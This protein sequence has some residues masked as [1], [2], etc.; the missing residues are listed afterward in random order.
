MEQ[1]ILGTLVDVPLPGT[2]RVRPAHL[3]SFASGSI[4]SV[5]P[6][7]PELPAH[8]LVLPPA[9]FLVP[10]FTDL[11]LHAPQYL[12][13]G[14]G[15]DRPLLEWLER[16]AYAAEEAVDASE[17]TARK[18]YGTLVRRLKAA[19][20]G[21]AV[22]FGTISVRSNII[23]A[24]AFL[25]AGIRGF[26]GK[27]SM[28][29][30]PRPSYSEPS[31]AASL[32]SARAYLADLSALLATYA[33]ERRTVQPV[34]TPRFV[35]TCSDE[36]L[37]G[38]AALAQEAGVW[39]QSHMCESAD[40][41]RWV[42]DTRGRAD[43]D[44][45]DE[46]GL[47]GERTVQ[48]HVTSLPPSLIDRVKDRGVTLAHCPLSNA[49]FSDAVF[50]LRE[51]LDADLKVGLGSDIAGGYALSLQTAM[52]SAVVVSRLRE[53]ARR[54]VERAPAVGAAPASEPETETETARSA[55]GEAAKSKS[56]GKSLRVDWVESLYLAT[57]GGKRALG[58]GGAFEVGMEFDAQ[59]IDL[60]ADGSPLD[61]FDLELQGE[62]W[63]EGVERWWC[64]GDDRNRVA[65][66]VAGRK[67]D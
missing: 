11:H 3:L 2:L 58:L 64:N 61:L 5:V 49:Y 48:A 22:V 17:D 19:G 12:Y 7:P 67:L 14:T 66:W 26:I 60:K 51:A 34:L 53:G 8:T 35:P 40:Q 37:R 15:L 43:E 50:P 6:R 63:A 25:N 9:S 21:C 33:P 30:S 18:V 56:Q 45:F 10:T 24:Q 27:L 38:L 65:M 1:H 29:Q 4:T 42:E 44:V 23:L 46:A 13:A 62:G 36:L 47:L 31:A 32:A 57:R 55:V 52:R 16:Y 54:Q 28:D 39:V 59:L 41:M 20:T